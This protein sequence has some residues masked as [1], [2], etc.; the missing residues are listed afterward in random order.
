LIFPAGRIKKLRATFS[1]KRSKRAG[2]G[3]ISGHR[4]VTLNGLCDRAAHR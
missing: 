1:A 3:L 2:F 4:T